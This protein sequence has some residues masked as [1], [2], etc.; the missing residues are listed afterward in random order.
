MFVLLIVL[1]CAA[2]LLLLPSSERAE[3]AGLSR[4]YGRLHHPRAS[5][6]LTFTLSPP[7]PMHV[8]WPRVLHV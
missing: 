3:A 5:F 2:C 4:C 8:A 7:L 1:Y 6:S